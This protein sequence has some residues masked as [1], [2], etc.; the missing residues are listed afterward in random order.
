MLPTR[1]PWSSTV[2]VVT[3]RTAASICDVFADCAA[4]R[5]LTVERLTAWT[6]WESFADFAAVALADRSGPGADA[7][8]YQW[9]TFAFTGRPQFHLVL[10][11][12]VAVGPPGADAFVQFDCRLRY[13]VDPTLGALGR[14]E[15]SWVADGAT[16][17]SAWLATVTGR[18]E[19]TVL[20]PLVP[21][22]V[23]ISGEQV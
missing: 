14:F 19:W 23:E 10:S 21:V 16:A 22:A 13:D 8:L 5:G 7:L 17:A 18:P 2:A 1:G 11:R 9:G 12:Q 20:A 6:A 4:A 15:S 3:S